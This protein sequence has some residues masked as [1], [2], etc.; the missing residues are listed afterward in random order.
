MAIEDL[1]RVEGLSAYE[2]WL[3]TNAGQSEAAFLTSLQGAAGVAYDVTYTSV[4][5]V[6]N[7]FACNVASSSVKNFYMTI[8][9]TTAKTITFT[10]V[11]SG[12]VEIFL[13]IKLTATAAITWTL[14]KNG[15]G[16]PVVKWA[17]EAPTPVTGKTYRI[18]FVTSDAG[19]NWAGYAAPGV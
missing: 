8:A 3:K 1:G 18:L 14:G 19:A 9:N 7:V 15:T 5:D 12:R 11:P 10:N 6:S 4:S 2:V 16:V 17:G 13:E